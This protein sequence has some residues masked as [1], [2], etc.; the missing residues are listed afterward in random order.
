MS[1][2]G[3]FSPNIGA[4]ATFINPKDPAC[5][6]VRG[7]WRTNLPE[8]Q[9]L[10]PMTTFSIQ[11]MSFGE[12]YMFVN[13]SPVDQRLIRLAGATEEE[14]DDIM[15]ACVNYG[16]N[17]ALIERPRTDD[18][19]DPLIMDYINSFGYTESFMSKIDCTPP[20]DVGHRANEGVDDPG[21]KPRVYPRNTGVKIMP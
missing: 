3:R 21:Q 7:W 9:L 10:N 15:E 13:Y 4:I 12:P 5:F 18:G 14:M 19:G 1:W 17:H 6:G 20:A 11:E 8:M 2:R 16:Q